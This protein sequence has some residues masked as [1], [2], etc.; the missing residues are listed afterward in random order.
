MLFY[1]SLINRGSYLSNS[2][3]SLRYCIDVLYNIWYIY[4][5]TYPSY[6]T[7][8]LLPS[9][10]AHY[11]NGKNP[12]IK[13]TYSIIQQENN[14]YMQRVQCN[15]VLGHA[16]F[17]LEV[18]HWAEAKRVVIALRSDKDNWQV[19]WQKR[20]MAK[21]GVTIR[22]GTSRSPSAIHRQSIMWCAL[23]WDE[24]PNPF[25]ILYC[26]LTPRRQLFW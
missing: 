20:W 12:I 23:L 15:I 13:V 9:Y 1:F 8:Y 21:P 2:S 18:G 22:V 26:K 24:C 19:L 3:V 16:L 4:C 17:R 6:P 7:D 5:R 25:L 10:S 14:H 11:S